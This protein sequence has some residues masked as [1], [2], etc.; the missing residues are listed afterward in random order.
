VT[1]AESR[2]GFP[3]FFYADKALR[4]SDRIG[5][6]SP[7]SVGVK[8]L[9]K[10]RRTCCLWV[11]TGYYLTTGG[12]TPDSDRRMITESDLVVIFCISLLQVFFIIVKLWCSS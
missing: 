6:H 11:M 7:D 1:A 3:S 9:S 4:Q 5:V 2:D 12:I 10:S 8:H